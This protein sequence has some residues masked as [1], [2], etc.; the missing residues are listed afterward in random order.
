VVCQYI[1]A[2]SSHAE[3]GV[4]KRRK[5]ARSSAV[6]REYREED[7][8]VPAVEGRLPS[9]FLGEVVVLL[10]MLVVSNV[11]AEVLLRKAWGVP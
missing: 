7:V 10:P 2:L 1:F 4:G 3:D 9:P 8:V 11:G 5:Q 6:K